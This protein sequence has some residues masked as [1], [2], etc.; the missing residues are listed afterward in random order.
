MKT[1]SR[2]GVLL[3]ILVLLL[4]AFACVPGEAQQINPS[5][6][7]TA[8]T[9]SPEAE[10]TLSKET[11]APT[12][13]EPQ[14]QFQDREP[15]ATPMTE[16]RLH[17]LYW[18]MASNEDGWYE[19]LLQPIFSDPKEINFSYLFSNGIPNA[20]TS[21]LTPEEIAYLSEYSDSVTHFDVDRISQ[22]KV[23]EVLC[24]YFDLTP[25]EALEIDLSD[26]IYMESTDCY[27]SLQNGANDGIP[28]FWEGYHADEN[29]IIIYYSIVGSNGNVRRAVLWNDPE[30]YT[31]VWK[32]L[33]IAS[34]EP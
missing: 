8:S 24:T 19:V 10:E 22:E 25:E 27:Y 18:Q 17:L 33:E 5:T 7:P 16:D 6:I 4:V 13:T 20:P 26:L 12:E 2:F 1:I 11:V 28:V 23:M 34:V 30:N 21:V 14:L 15:D 31:G 29:T 3:M 32:I 9:T